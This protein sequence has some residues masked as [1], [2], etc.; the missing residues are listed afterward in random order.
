MQKTPSTAG[1]FLKSFTL[2]FL[3]FLQFSFVFAQ[4]ASNWKEATSAGYTYKFVANDPTQTRYYTLK[5]GLTVVLSVNKKEPR[6]RALMPVRAGSNTDPRTNTGLAHY[7]EHMLFKGTDKFGVL[8]WASEKP[9]LDKIDALYEQYNKTT[10]EAKRKEIYKEIDQ[11]SGQAAK[12]SIANEYDKMMKNMGGKNTNAHTWYEETV[13]E[14]D[15]PSN[16]IDRYLTLQAERFRNPILRIFHTELEAVYEEKNR[17]LDNDGN[18]AFEML[19]QTIFPTHNYGQQTTIGTIE[20]LKNPSLV[21]IRNYYNKNYVPNNM[22][23]IF[24]GDFSPDEV[25]KKI[26]TAFAYMQPKPVEE[27]NP[28]PELPL[29]GE[30]VKEVVGP[31][32]DMVYMGFRVPGEKNTKEAVLV[33]IMDE[34]LSNSQAGLI[35]LNLNKQQKVLNSGCTPRK[36][37]DYSVELFYGYPKQGQTVEEVKDL[38]LSQIKLVQ[39]GKFDESII[40]AI[41]ANYKLQRIKTLEDNY[42]RADELSDVFIRTKGD[43]WATEVA[44]A[45]AMSKVTKQEVIDFAKKYFSDGYVVVYKRKGEDKSIVKVEK[46]AITAVETNSDKS[47]PY[48]TQLNSTPMQPIKPI[49]VDYKKDFKKDVI[50]GLDLYYVQNKDNDLFRLNYRFEMGSWNNK[51]LPLAAQ[52]LQYLSTDKYSSEEISKEFY[53]IA[54]SY[55][56]NPSNEFTT[57]SV[58]GLQENFNSSVS[59]FEHLLSNCKVDEQAWQSL[60]ARIIK[61]RNDAKANRQAIRQGLQ[62]FAQFGAKNPFNFVLT[63]DELNAV[64]AQDLIDLLHN[65]LKYKHQVIYFGPKQLV[66]VKADIQKLHAVPASFIAIPAKAEFRKVAQEKPQ[67]LFTN[68]EMVQAEINWIRNTDSYSSKYSPIVAVFNSYFGAGGFT[69]LVPQI[70]RESKAL[71]YST[72]AIYA[73]PNKSGDKYTMNAYIGAQADKLHEAIGGMNELLTDLPQ[74][75]NFL[76][77]AKTAIKNNYE[78][79]RLQQDEVIFDY[80]NA[81]RKGLDGDERKMIYEGVDTITYE[82]LKKFHADNL[83]KKPYTMC[84]VA[85]DK[86]INTKDLEKYGEVKTVS[87]EELFGY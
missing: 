60:K 18:K 24:V 59:L 72:N 77:S 78:T 9:L 16:A 8:D 29:K 75:D 27:Y 51:L 15:I 26:D 3:C 46:P 44:K 4:N 48:L 6:I 56:M 31:T 42:S 37:K 83:S 67:V 71:A 34:L 36:S 68:Y 55:A 86:K 45:D 22:A 25:I 61:S 7:L 13:Y 82:D 85:S 35:D 58:T 84:V 2:A 54:G 40:K 79:T 62:Q 30:I 28:A 65:I 11:V 74:V 5:N 53:K 49:W 70:L 33:T 39:E 1:F 76:S 64:K 20:H 50:K 73:T 21:E 69:S 12:F 10:D 23:V 14:E 57:L 66:E 81:Q 32:P 19:F 17:S 87:L 52:Y 41:A 38:L 80:F 63:N 43:N 47:S